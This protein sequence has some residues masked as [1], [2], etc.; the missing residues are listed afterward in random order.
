MSAPT[1]NV[2][3]SMTDEQ[4]R[5]EHDRVAIT[6]N[7]VTPSICLEELFRREQ[8]RQT[9]QMLRY[10]NQIKFYTLVV[11]IATIVSMAVTIYSLLK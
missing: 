3:K 9:N 10:T 11:T 8:N 1:Y 4:I 5:Q 7:D 6:Q 2:L